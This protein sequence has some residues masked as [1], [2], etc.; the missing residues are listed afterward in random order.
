M[1]GASALAVAAWNAPA[2]VGATS[3]G[4]KSHDGAFDVIVI[5]G[6]FAG[7]TATR[8]LGREGFEVLLLEGRDRLGGR[9]FTGKF[10]SHTTEFGGTWI[11]WAQPHV[12]A[13][14]P[15]PG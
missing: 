8:E 6:G 12:W 13:I 9:T 5:G 15:R 10:G 7:V 2:L 4:R 14:R 11:H 1:A 3:A